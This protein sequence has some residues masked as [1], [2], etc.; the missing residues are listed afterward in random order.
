M[1][2]ARIVTGLLLG[3]VLGLP[4]P[5][6]AEPVGYVIDP[7]HFSI[8]FS[9][10][11]LGYVDLVGLFT[12]GEGS[13]RYDQQ[14]RTLSD[15][16]ITIATDSIFTGHEERDGHL[17]SADF[18]NV[19]EF[20]EMTFV[21]TGAEATGE[22][23]GRVTGDL[24]LIGQTRPVTLDVT[25][26]QISDYP[27][28]HGKETIGASATGLIRRSDFGMTYFVPGVSDEIP[29]TLGFEANRED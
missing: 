12:E 11:H 17:K 7:S 28:T 5:S 20:P 14:T 1:P 10:D 24:T 3:L 9:A 29:L 16:S 21:M 8:S 22:R 25:L 26:N 6:R 18:L 2:L 15:L 27:M 13:F 19:A 4:Q 23:T